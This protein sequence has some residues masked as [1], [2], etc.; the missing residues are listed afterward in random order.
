M[1]IFGGEVNGVA[2]ENAIVT[3]IKF[4]SVALWPN[5]VATTKSANEN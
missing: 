1:Q 2:N 3:Y 5:D 4:K